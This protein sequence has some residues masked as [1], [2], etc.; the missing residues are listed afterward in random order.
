[1]TE[2]AEALRAEVPDLDYLPITVDISDE[3]QVILAFEATVSKFGRIDYAINNAAIAAP[4]LPTAETTLADFERVQRVN[5]RGTWLCEREALK[6]ML[7]QEPLEA[8]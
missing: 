6:Q 5:V 2:T 1:M 7:K 4:F 8:L 3:E